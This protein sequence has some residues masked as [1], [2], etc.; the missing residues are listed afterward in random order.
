MTRTSYQIE[1]ETADGEPIAM[2]TAETRHRANLLAVA[3]MTIQPPGHYR[4][5]T[6]RHSHSERRDGRTDSHLTR[7]IGTRRVNHR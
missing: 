7:H 3:A 6:Y 4:I 5:N 2:L 1:I